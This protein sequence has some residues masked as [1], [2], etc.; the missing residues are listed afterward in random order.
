MSTFKL[1]TIQ[2]K[3]DPALADRWSSVN[4]DQ[5]NQML[6]ASGLDK[7]TNAS[8]YVKKHRIET[9]LKDI[10]LFNGIIR[11]VSI[12]DPVKLLTFQYRERVDPLMVIARLDNMRVK[13]EQEVK[14]EAM[15][16]EEWFDVGMSI[17]V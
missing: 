16:N 14:R 2:V 4:N 7:Y 5:L 6:T 17:G 8:D 15:I 13:R 10:N 11:K 3:E 12:P 9:F 1:P